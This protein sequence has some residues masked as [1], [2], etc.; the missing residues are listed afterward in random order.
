M[1]L[2]FEPNLEYQQEAVGA[3]VGLF[4]GQTFEDSDYRYGMREDGQFDFIDGVGNH[5][6]LTEGQILA[7]LQK[8]QEQTEVA[9]SESLDGM[10]FSI[11]METGT[12]KTYVYLRTIYEL[13]SKY[14]FKKFVIVVPSVPIREGVLKN[15]QITHDHFQTLYNNTPVNYKVYDRNR[16]SQLRGFATNDNIEIL[17]INIDAFAKDENVINKPNDKLNGQEPIR[18]IQSTAPIVIVD[19]PQNM[20]SEKRSA[21]IANLNPLCTL[22]YSATHR[23]RYNLTYSLNPIKAYDMGLVKQIEV[24][25]VLEENSQNGAFVELT[26]IT[27]TKTKI[28]AKVTIDIND[29]DGVK[30]KSVRVRAGDNLYDLSNNREV[31]R[32]GYIVEGIDASNGLISFS[33]NKVLYQGQRQGGQNDEIMKF[34]I[35]R[36]IEEHLNKELKLNKQG[37]KVLSLFFIDRVANYRSYDAQG[38]PVKGKFAVW[39]EE[40]YKELISKPTYQSLNRHSIDKIHN[41]YFSQDKK[42]KL[43]DTSGETQAD[44]NT[45]N[46]IMKDKEMLLDINNPLRFIFSHTALREGWDNPNVFQICTLNETKSEMKKRQE[47]GRGLRLAV[48]Q[49]GT[50]IYDKSINRL[51]VVANEAYNDFAKALQNELKADCGVD[52]GNRIK[53]KRNRI[54]VTYRKGF[55]A[56]PLFLAIWEKLKTRTTYRVKYDTE[57]LIKNAGRAIGNLPKMER[58]SVR[59]IKNEVVIT[60][61]GMTAQY[62][63]DWISTCHSDHVIPDALGYIQRH[64]D[65]TRSTIMRIITESGRM[66]DLAVN[67]QLFMDSVI[68]SI[69]RELHEMMIDGIEYRRMGDCTYEMRLFEDWETYKGEYT[70][71]VSKKDK[72][73]YDDFIPLDSAVENKFAQDCESSDQV[74]FYF[75]LPGWFNI[76][77]PIGSYN[78]DWAVVFKDDRRI[79]FVAETKDTGTPTVDISKLRP[80]EQAKIKCGAAHF[81][82]FPDL[83]YQVVN[84]VSGLKR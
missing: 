39:F 73:I 68:A 24:D 6:V 62:K 15:L 44:D 60:G 2:T 64:T 66:D 30:R 45:Y 71:E 27:A 48:N 37:I 11:E 67:P 42:G 20:E 79:Y 43:K 76:P 3:V 77:T 23:N 21:A 9:V 36:T 75:K 25:S 72:T 55:E 63:G 14:G 22:R 50:R 10:H 58:P 78:P 38:T 51:T 12:G 81:R 5:L 47:I 8:V 82:Q 16:I 74:K 80:E 69:K 18:F 61:A 29:R 34:Q 57:E 19:E 41:G 7:N 17:V 33:N 56:D 84:S 83:D 65:L 52:F 31:Y 54:A 70:F 13:N 40:I 46:L 49:D 32:E 26:A 59:S 4:E 1:K 35:R 28:T 53:P